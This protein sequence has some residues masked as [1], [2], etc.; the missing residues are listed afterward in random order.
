MLG[1][2]NINLCH[3]VF[4]GPTKLQQSEVILIVGGATLLTM[5][6]EPVCRAPSM[7]GKNQLPLPHCGQQSELQV[8]APM[9]F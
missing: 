5:L 8:R 9:V 3:P 4:P 1:Q 7:A 2:V 6:S